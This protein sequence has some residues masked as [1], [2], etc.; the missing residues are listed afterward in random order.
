VAGLWE[1]LLLMPSQSCWRPVCC[2]YFQCFWHPRCSKFICCWRPCCFLRSYVVNTPFPPVLVTLSLLA[3]PD[4]SAL[5]FVA[6]DPAIAIVLS[7]VHV[8]SLLLLESLLLP[9]PP[10]TN[11]SH[12]L[13]LLTKK[14]LTPNTEH[15]QRKILHKLSQRRVSLSPSTY[16]ICISNNPENRLCLHWEYAAW[17]CA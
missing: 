5:T 1:F 8:E 16:H 15:T 2:F 6:F 9:A 10:T 4:D 14:W 3:S 13:H 11:V 12:L 7:A 17:D